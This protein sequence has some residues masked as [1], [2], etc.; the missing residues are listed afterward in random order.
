MNK[1]KIGI[2]LII[3]GNLLYLAYTFF[4]SHETTPFAEFSSGLLLGLALGVNLVGII[5]LTIYI[6]KK[7][8]V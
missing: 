7:K 8:E 4:C 2:F 1:G 6:S 3:L 5:L